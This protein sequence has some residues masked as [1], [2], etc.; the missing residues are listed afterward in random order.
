MR[1]HTGHVLGFRVLGIS[2][3]FLTVSAPSATLLQTQTS[4]CSSPPNG[5]ALFNFGHQ[6]NAWS[7]SSR[8]IYLEGFVDGQ[9]NTYLLLQNDLPKERREPHRQQTFAFFDSDALRDVMTSLYSDPA[10]TYIRYDSMVYIARDK[11][12][13]MD[14]EPKLR[15]ARRSDCGFTKH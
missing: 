9:S 7:N 1:N 3:L 11:L 6:W 13:G 10:N 2:L 4:F 14:I 5:Q 12:A 8:S 15:V